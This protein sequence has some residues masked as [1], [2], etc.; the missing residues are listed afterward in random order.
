MN[1]SQGDLQPAERRYPFL[2]CC[3]N[4]LLIIKEK[5]LIKIKKNKTHKSQPAANPGLVPVEEVSY[6]A[7]EQ[8]TFTKS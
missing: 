2:R 5:K 1:E 4:L 7:Q 6:A 8:P 3:R